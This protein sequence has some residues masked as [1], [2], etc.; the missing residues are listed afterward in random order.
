MAYRPAFRQLSRPK[1]RHK[2]FDVAVSDVHVPADERDFVEGRAHFWRRGRWSD[3]RCGSDACTPGVQ[4]LAI[5]RGLGREP[6]EERVATRPRHRW[7]HD[8]RT[9]PRAGA[10]ACKRTD[11]GKQRKKPWNTTI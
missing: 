1:V 5:A 11:H 9:N 10:G 2:R 8:G 6:L 3:E 7:R 4:P